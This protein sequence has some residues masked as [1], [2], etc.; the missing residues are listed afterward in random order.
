VSVPVLASPP[1]KLLTRMRRDYPEM[2]VYTR[3]ELSRKVQVYWLFRSTGGTVMVC[4][5]SLALLVGLVVTSQTLHAAVLASLRE[6]AVL[7]AL[8][9]PRWRLLS[10]AL[11]QSLW[12]GLA[13]LAIALP[14]C[15]GLSY[16]ALLL[17]TRIILPAPLLL[18]T[19]GLTLGMAVL[20]GL[21]ALR[22]RCSSSTTAKS[23]P[24]S[25]TPLTRH[26]QPTPLLSHPRLPF[27]VGLDKLCNSVKL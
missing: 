18:A 9:V 12:I 15:F 22:V 20:S 7:D 5:I 16:A 26:N 1:K 3:Q 17:H 21:W 24:A 14:V 27:P 6:Y 11:F 23:S 25:A 10:L 2:G 19:V 8:G 13:G 4:T